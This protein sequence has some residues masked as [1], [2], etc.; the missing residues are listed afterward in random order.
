MDAYQEN[1]EKYVT[2]AKEAKQQLVKEQGLGCDLTSGLF[3][4]R[5][6]T[7]LIVWSDMLGQLVA[8]TMAVQVMRPVSSTVVAEVFYTLGLPPF[9][10]GQ[11]D[12]R[13]RFAEGDQEVVEALAIHTVAPERDVLSYLVPYRYEGRTVVWGEPRDTAGVIESAFQN[14]LNNAA[15][16]Q[17]PQE[18]LDA[19]EP[20]VGTTEG[21]MM[22]A[23][24]IRSMLDVEIAVLTGTPPA[25]MF[26]NE[27]SMN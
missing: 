26:P 24:H 7:S 27:P 9:A 5:D 8:A 25:G 1:H 23:A 21:W 15:N 18:I 19:Y 20:M 22:L 17:P 12:L 13:R 6:D 4:R 16:C 14:A 3:A 2:W 11:T 10:E